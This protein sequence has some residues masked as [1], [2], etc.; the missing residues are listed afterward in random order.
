MPICQT[1]AAL[2]AGEVGVDDAIANLLS[3]PLR[4]EN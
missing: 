3:R 4:R 1:T 2:L